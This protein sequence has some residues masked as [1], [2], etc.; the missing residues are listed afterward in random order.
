MQPELLTLQYFSQLLHSMCTYISVYQS[1]PAGTLFP[2]PY[3]L[4]LRRYLQRLK[5]FRLAMRNPPHARS[6]VSS[7]HF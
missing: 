2:Q 4:K 1:V 6:D 7:N 3:R 5:A